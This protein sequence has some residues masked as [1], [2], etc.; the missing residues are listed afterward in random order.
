MFLR[1]LSPVLFVLGLSACA[2]TVP[3]LQLRSEHPASPLAAEAP[4]SAVSSTL[5]QED[6]LAAGELA[7]RAPEDGSS[8]DPMNHANHDMAAGMDHATMT[9]ES[10][11]SHDSLQLGADNEPAAAA[12]PDVRRLLSKR[13]DPEVRWNQSDTVPAEISAMADTLLREPLSVDSAVQ[14]ALLNNRRLQATYEALGISQADL[15]QAGLL[16]NPVLVGSSIRADGNS[17]RSLLNLGIA[18]NFLSILLRPARKALAAAQYEQAKLQVGH[19]V[20]E[21]VHDVEAAYYEATASHQLVAVQGLLVEAA[22]ASSD[23]ALR[24]LEAGNSSPI[25]EAKERS[26][27]EDSRVALARSEG[28]ALEAREHLTELLGLWGPRVGFDLPAELPELPA[29]LPKL[30]GLETLAVQNRFDLAA[31][32]REV[33]ILAAAL[34]VTRNW[35]LIAVAEIGIDAERELDGEWLYGPTLAIE[36]PVFDRRQAQVARLEA[37]LRRSEQNLAS[38]AV[39]IRSE[40]RVQR[41]RLA[42]SHQL[43][44]H[45]REVIIPLRQ[46][47]VA[48]TQQQYNFMLTG[49]FELLTAKQDEYAAYKESIEAAHDYWQAWA[50]LQ[51]AVGYSLAVSPIAPLAAPIEPAGHHNHEEPGS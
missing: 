28:Q 35:R 10:A 48:L 49:V 24:L 47:I 41:E 40:V 30:D 27:F 23:M 19:A 14:V 17:S 38:L 29:E 3:S 4:P 26:R 13:I 21:L 36:I 7:R 15:V 16:E 12:A 2:A 9:D 46:R 37:E 25:D 18:Q 31:A 5:T 45:Y 44:I 20:L 11:S 42:M 50:A 33:E 34:G 1:R 8:H 51:H 22:R 43:V 32:G 39:E 6:P